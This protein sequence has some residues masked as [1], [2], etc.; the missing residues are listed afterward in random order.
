M[1]DPYWISKMNENK[2][3]IWT[4]EY[5]TSIGYSEGDAV[6]KVKEHQSENSKKRDYIKSPSVL[7]MKYYEDR[8]IDEGIALET[9]RRIQSDLS[10]YSD[11]FKGKTHSIESKRKIRNTMS[12]HVHGVG[13]DKWVGHFGD[14]SH[15]IFRSKGEIE[16][17]NIVSDITN[18]DIS[19][20]VYIDGYNVDILCGNKVI[21]YFGTYWHCDPTVY[22]PEYLHMKKNKKACEIWKFDTKKIKKLSENGYS[23][24]VIWEREFDNGVDYIK[25]KINKFLYG[26]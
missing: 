11:K 5:W 23:V 7:S 20:N 10:K 14:L 16:L 12:N 8:G 13:I 9:I 6:T 24:I 4:V 21:E 17:F 2:K 3:S 19:A 18:G 15:P 22:H 26:S 25:D 1:K